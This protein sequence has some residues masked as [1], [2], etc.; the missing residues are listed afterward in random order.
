[1]WLP[2]AT[3]DEIKQ[4]WQNLTT[5]KPGDYPLLPLLMSRWMELAPEDALTATAGTRYE[6][7]PWAAWGKVNPE[8]AVQE[9]KRRN[10]GY[11]ARVLEGAAKVQPEFVRRLLD[12]NPGMFDLS[13]RTTLA[14]GMESDSWQS[15]LQ[16]WFHWQ[17]LESWARDDPEKSWEWALQNSSKVRGS[18]DDPWLG[19]VGPMLETDPAKVDAAI[20]KLP[21]GRVKSEII[22][23]KAKA[24][25]SSDPAA[26]LAMLDA[27]E[28]GEPRQHLLMAIGPVLLEKDP[29]RSL[30]IFRELAA[31]SM[32]Q[33]TLLGPGEMMKSEPHWVKSQYDEWVFPLL[34]RDPAAVMDGLPDQVTRDIIEDWE[35]YDL[36]GYG[37]WL[38]GQPPGP[39]KDSRSIEVARTFAR[40][41]GGYFHNNYPAAFEWVQRLSD[42]ERRES[43]GEELVGDWLKENPG[44]ADDYF[45]KEDALLKPAYAKLKQK[46]TP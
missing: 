37:A 31:S 14:K 44:E 10:S 27:A 13:M 25:A 38:A 24:L 40:G 1:M 12:Q 9:A 34:Q 41:D 43:F 36:Q 8:L 35:N 42:P 23:A 15:S 18:Y 22:T 45:S 11:L 6:A 20:A 39:G 33:V 21:D 3:P 32:Q 19:V 29:D 46:G 26:A 28:A 17:K 7:M 5:T 2:H 4:F 16:F 30:K